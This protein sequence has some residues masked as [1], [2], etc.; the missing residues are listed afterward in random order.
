MSTSKSVART[1]A[2]AAADLAEAFDFAGEELSQASNVVPFQSYKTSRPMP[3]TLSECVPLLWVALEFINRAPMTITI[4][5]IDQ[6]RSNAM[7]L[8]ENVRPVIEAQAGLTLASW[9]ANEFAVSRPDEIIARLTDAFERVA[10]E[11]ADPATGHD[12]NA[13]VPAA[14]VECVPLLAV[15]L[16]FI[17]RGPAALTIEG[18]EH[19][20]ASTICLLEHIRP[21]V[22]QEARRTLASWTLQL[23]DEPAVAPLA[24]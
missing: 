10:G 18:V 22:E 14:L 15:A 7:R 11:L 9:A 12:D 19:Y 13:T 23:D 20:R 8:I 4:E 24:A 21:A 17:D 3:A 6:Y 5:R 16:E 2:F 1:I